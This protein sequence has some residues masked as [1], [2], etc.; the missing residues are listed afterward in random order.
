MKFKLTLLAFC[1]G[2][3]MP[4]FADHG[5]LTTGSG[6]TLI[7]PETLKRFQLSTGIAVA[8]SQYERLS[9]AFIQELTLKNN[10]PGA[11]VDAIRQSMLTTIS[12]GFGITDALETGVR[13]RY[14]R[15]EGVREG[16]IDSGGTYRSIN[17]GNIGG[18]A[19]P[20]IYA[21]YR[22]WKSERHTL[23]IA[24]YAKVPLGKYY[25]TAE[26]KPLSTYAG[27]LQPKLH[28][29]GGGNAGDPLSEKYTIEPSLTPGSGAWDFSGALAWSMWLG[30]G[31]SLTSSILYTRRTAA[32]SYKVGDSIEGGVSLQRRWGSR[33]E[34]NFSIFTE[35]AMR[36]WGA[37][38]AYSEAIANTGGT[39]V[40][41]SPGVVFAWPSGISAS[42]FLQL[43][44]M[45]YINEPQQYL[46]YRAGFSVAYILGL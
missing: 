31:T 7:E 37:A 15:G 12:A 41:L 2:S 34:V 16:I 22:F 8:M 10:K 38:V 29:A 23:S 24:A 43:P 36:H 44:L 1:C 35:M 13:Y 18:S 4:V 19:D 39:M 5:P 6:A 20:D 30:E 33:D 14:Y 45:R 46:E 42:A 32:Q 17:L 25:T 11:H 3:I 21:K 9:D 40:F 26:A 28:L 27:Q